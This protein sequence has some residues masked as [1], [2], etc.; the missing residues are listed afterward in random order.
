MKRRSIWRFLLHC[1]LMLIAHAYGLTA[2]DAAFLE[3][4][5]LLGLPLAA[6][7]GGVALVSG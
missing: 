2:Y 4:A 6:R 3:L 1:G 7:A 5:K